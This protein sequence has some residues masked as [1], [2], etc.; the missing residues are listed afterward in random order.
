[1]VADRADVLRDALALGEPPEMYTAPAGYP[2][3]TRGDLPAAATGALLGQDRPEA[4]RPAGPGPRR[5]R[6]LV[7]V[8]STAVLCAAAAAIGVYLSG[9]SGR[10]NTG[11]VGSN[12]AQH[13]SS[14]TP[15]PTLSASPSPRPT[16]SPSLV[17]VLPSVTS[18]P[19]GNPRPS[20]SV[21]PKP[22][23]TSSPTTSASASASSS[24]SPTSSPSSTSSPTSTSSP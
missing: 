16:P 10:A 18:S 4:G 19:A 7:A 15:T 3:A 17:R 2:G 22:S 14:P 12:T 11:D 21:K 5:R 1:V 20:K 6:Q 24:T 13:L 23:R 8:G 9:H